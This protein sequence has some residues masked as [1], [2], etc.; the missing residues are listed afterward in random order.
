MQV[1]AISTPA[2]PNWRW[3]IT[4]YA[5]ETVEESRTTFPTIAT[6]IADGTRRLRAMDVTDRSVPP[7]RFSRS[8]A[9]SRGR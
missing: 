5:C 6:A 1:S 2:Q 8:T 3:R 7:S 4:N 9:H